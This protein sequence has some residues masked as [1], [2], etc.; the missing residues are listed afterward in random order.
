MVGGHCGS[1]N[2]CDLV[3]QLTPRTRMNESLKTACIN[4]VREGLRNK[5]GREAIIQSLRKT[6][7]PTETVEEVY[8]I[9]E[10]GLKDGV[11]SAF[12]DGISSQCSTK[13]QSSL[14][15]AAF[16][17]GRLA[18]QKQHWFTRTRQVFLAAIIVL[19]LGILLAR[20]SRR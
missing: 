16:E 8:Q 11:L 18:Y 12:T 6:S 19:L 14:Y 17:S 4:I 20:F 15:D 5:A 1:P 3:N 2:S 13:S 9:I 10:K 7:I